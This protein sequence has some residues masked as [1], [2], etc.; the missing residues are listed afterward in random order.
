MLNALEEADFSESL[1]AR[2]RGKVPTRYSDVI[3]SVRQTYG[4]FK[5]LRK[6]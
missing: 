6:P 1:E 5:K 3:A 2:Q 4:E